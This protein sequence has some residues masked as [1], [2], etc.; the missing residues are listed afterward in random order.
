MLSAPEAIG[1][2]TNQDSTLA[3]VLDAVMTNIDANSWHDGGMTASKIK[4]SPLAEGAL[5]SVIGYHIAKARVATQAL[6]V[7]HIGKPF[8]LRPV[9]YSVLM[10]LRANSDLTPKKLSR[11]LSLS[12][13]NLTIL[14]DRLQNNGLIERV[15]SEIDRRSQQVLLTAEGS[16]FADDLARRTPQME[17][18]LAHC[19][20]PGERAML[21]ELLNKVSGYR[22]IEVDG[23]A[24]E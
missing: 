19:L 4:R 2:G 14:L 1:L 15:R 3:I 16:V 24:A 21:V 18:E 22:H 6:Y 12:G 13:P 20:T 7:R 9:E 11:A 8:K 10:L 5:E 17:A 23:E